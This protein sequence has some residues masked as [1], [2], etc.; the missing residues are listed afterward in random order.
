MAILKLLALLLVS[1]LIVC[2]SAVFFP[3]RRWKDEIEQKNDH[4]D[5]WLNMVSDE[6]SKTDQAGEDVC[7]PCYGTLLDSLTLL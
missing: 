4:M 3:R 2:S 7:V 1:F 6:T 5:G